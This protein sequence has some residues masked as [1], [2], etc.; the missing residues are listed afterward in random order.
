V[1]SDDRSAI[2]AIF[3]GYAERVLYPNLKSS[4]CRTMKNLI[5]HLRKRELIEERRCELCK[6]AAERSSTLC[7]R[8]EYNKR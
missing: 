4:T 5:A 7:L 6:I 2:V 1:Y 3:E 8:H